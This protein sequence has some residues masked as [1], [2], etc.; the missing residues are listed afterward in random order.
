VLDAAYVARREAAL[1][2][3]S[4]RKTRTVRLAASSYVPSVLPMGWAPVLRL[5][6]P[7][8]LAD[9]ACPNNSVSVVMLAAIRRASSRVSSLPPARARVL[10]EIDIAAQKNAGFR[11]TRV[12]SIACCRCCFLGVAPG[13]RPEPANVRPQPLTNPYSLGPS[14]QKTTRDGSPASSGVVSGGGFNDDPWAGNMHRY[15]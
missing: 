9:E 15:G 10:L 8:S 3:G 1:G 12:E 7:L 2:R 4:S 6:E 5:S 13:E 11:K 14:M